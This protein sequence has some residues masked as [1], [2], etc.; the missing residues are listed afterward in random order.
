MFRR[1]KR[2]AD[3]ESATLPHIPELY[4]AALRVVGIETDAEDVTQQVYLQ[5]WGSLD[6]F[7][8]GTHPRAWL[9]NYTFVV[10]DLTRNENVEVA[11]APAGSVR[12]FL[13]QNT[14]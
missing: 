13:S 11:T 8:M 6:R 14:I 10:S 12:E 2:R 7:E 4:R 3:F 1:G 5:A 9:F